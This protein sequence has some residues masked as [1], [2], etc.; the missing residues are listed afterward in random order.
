M[1]RPLITLVV[2]VLGVGLA[3]E[4]GGLLPLGRGLGQPEPT[5]QSLFQGIKYER[6]VQQDPRPMV[7]HIVTI[8][9]KAN[10]IKTMVTPGDPDAERPLEARTTSEFLRDFDLQL[11]INGDAFT[12]WNDLGPLGFYPR[13]G[14]RVVPNG[15]AASRGTIYSQDSDE[16][17]TLYIYQNN[18]ASLNNLVG[19]IYNAVSGYQ[20]VVWGG[21]ALDDL[22]NHDAEP[23][24]AIG[25]DRPGR[26]LVIVVVDGR[27]PGYSEGATLAD[28]SQ[29]FLDNRVFRGMNMDGGGSSTLVIERNGEPFVLNSPVHQ[30]ISGNERPVGNHLG[31]SANN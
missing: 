23:R 22:D 24:T 27:Q 16:Q 2:F 18:K 7:I 28:L 21:N 19:K 17:P 29:I 31:F 20:L 13:E 9:L 8:D 4:V 3:C 14:E 25:L 6:I 15:F 1:S 5:T 26:R 11:A 30:G 10:G 12:P